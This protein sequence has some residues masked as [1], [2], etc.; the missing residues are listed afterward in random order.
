VLDTPWPKVRRLRAALESWLAAAPGPTKTPDPTPL[1]AA[2]ADR[3]CARPNDLPQTG[4]SAEWELRLSA[5]FVQRG[6]YGTRCSTLLLL[7]HDG[8]VDIEERSFDMA[9]QPTA[10][11]NWRLRADEWV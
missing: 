5:A 1:W 11:A 8:A 3:E 6:D 7:G 2:L 9:G 10:A 4:L